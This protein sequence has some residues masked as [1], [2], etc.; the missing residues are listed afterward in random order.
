MSKKTPTPAPLPKAPPT[1]SVPVRETRL[2][3]SF[4]YGP[5]GGVFAGLSGSGGA[6]ANILMQGKP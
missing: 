1:Q 4:L 5:T 3:R 2:K 6:M